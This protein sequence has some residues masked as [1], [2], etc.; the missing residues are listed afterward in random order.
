[1]SRP[2]EAELVTTAAAACVDSLSA[3][4]C[5]EVVKLLQC[6][7]H[8]ALCCGSC[9]A[10][11]TSSLPLDVL[12]LSTTGEAHLSATSAQTADESGATGSTAA[13]VIGLVAGIVTAALIA[14]AILFRHRQK[15]ALAVVMDVPKKACPLP[16]A[17]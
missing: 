2:D 16:E 3:D 5:A 13:L 6:D 7:Y 17:A 12:G 4:A 11:S 8:A 14:A 15:R 1:M 9:T 10:N